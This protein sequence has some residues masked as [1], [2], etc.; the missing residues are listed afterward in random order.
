[1]K[2]AYSPRAGV[3]VPRPYVLN[4]SGAWESVSPEAIQALPVIQIKDFQAIAE[5]GGL[6][7]EELRNKI[8]VIPFDSDP[9][10]APLPDTSAKPAQ[11]ENTNSNSNN[12]TTNKMDK[13]ALM[14]AD[15]N[16]RPVQ[17]RADIPSEDLS[18][19]EITLTLDASAPAILDGD[20]VKIRVGGVDSLFNAVNPIPA[21]PA[22][23]VVD[24]TYGA[25]TL[26][27]LRD[28]AVQGY[29]IKGIQETVSARGVLPQQ[30]AFTNAEALVL[31]KL[32]LGD[33]SVSK[34]NFAYQKGVGTD[35]FNLTNRIFE[36][37]K[38]EVTPSTGFIRTLPGGTT[39]TMILTLVK[40]ATPRVY[41]YKEVA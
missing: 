16:G 5:K 7:W 37:L 34:T 6:A 25:A 22:E 31:F 39:T 17:V 29:V 11:I 2:Q 14:M 18:Q 12:N 13:S 20:F 3:L 41:A 36:N 10:K 30:K 38:L 21:A 4:N 15:K 33:L 19:R 24:G 1:M 8:Q 28:W 26:N 35:A 23:F 9:T 40:I 32:N 27:I